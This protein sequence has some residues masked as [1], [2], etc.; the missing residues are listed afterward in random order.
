MVMNLPASFGGGE[1]VGNGKGQTDEENKRCPGSFPEPALDSASP[2]KCECHPTDRE[3][4]SKQVMVDLFGG[5][6]EVSCGTAVHPEGHRNTQQ[7]G[8]KHQPPG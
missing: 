7:Q 1:T 5:V 3:R 8:G 4:H 6:T 2:R